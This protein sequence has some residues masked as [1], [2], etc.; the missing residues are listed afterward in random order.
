[1]L[2]QTLHMRVASNTQKIQFSDRPA[3]D[4]QTIQ[5]VCSLAQN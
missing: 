3:R 2:C 1:M 5:T 4:I